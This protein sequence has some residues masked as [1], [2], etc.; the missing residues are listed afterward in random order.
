[1]KNNPL[2]KAVITAM[3]ILVFIHYCY[4]W[5][6]T[7]SS[8]INEASDKFAF[9]WI[10]FVLLIILINQQYVFDSKDK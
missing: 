3:P 1:M 8:K 5:Y 2:N 10:F 4:G 7:Y 9:A 6:L